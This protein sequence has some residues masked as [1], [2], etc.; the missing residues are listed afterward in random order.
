MAKCLDCGSKIDD[1]TKTK[2]CRSCA[3]VA[4]WQ[5]RLKGRKYYEWK[6]GQ[7]TSAELYQLACSEYGCTVKIEGFRIRLKHWGVKGALEG[8]RPEG[9]CPDT[10]QY[11]RKNN[12]YAWGFHEKSNREKEA[13]LQS[14]PNPTYY[15][16]Q[17][18]GEPDE[19]ATSY[20]RATGRTRVE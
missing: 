4:S 16:K 20:D 7:W 12:E 10:R 8:R 14:I 13:I 5:K 2:R 3:G 11:N 9:V 15:D 19:F 17:F 6:G 18:E 1:R